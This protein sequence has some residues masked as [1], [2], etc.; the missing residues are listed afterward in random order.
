MDVVCIWERYESMEVR[1]WAVVDEMTPCLP[2][3]P[4]DVC[5]LILESEYLNI[6]WQKGLC[7]CNYGLSILR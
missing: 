6:I 5:T 7:K 1:G 2:S 4:K 3:P